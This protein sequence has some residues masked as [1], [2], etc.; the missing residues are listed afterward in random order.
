MEQ[1]HLLD[2]VENRNTAVQR[3]VWLNKAQG[4]GGA[5][6]RGAEKQKVAGSRPSHNNHKE[7]A[8]AAGLGTKPP[9]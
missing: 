9:Q 2:I 3:L 7:Q 6:C 8:P 5:V 4:G 1:R